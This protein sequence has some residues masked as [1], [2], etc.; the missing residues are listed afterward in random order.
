MTLRQHHYDVAFEAW[1]QDRRVPYVAVDETFRSRFAEESLKSFDFVVSLPPAWRLLVDVK[2]RLL[3]GREGIES[4]ATTDD[5]DSLAR[6]Q[7]VF[8][9]GFRATLLFAYSDRVGQGP[10]GV[11]RRNSAGVSA[12]ASAETS[13]D[14]WFWFRGRRYQFFGVWADDYRE[15]MR[16]RSPKWQT[17]WLRAADFRELRWPLSALWNGRWTAA[18]ATQSVA[19]GAVGNEPDGAAGRASGLGGPRSICR[20]EQRRDGGCTACVR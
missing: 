13:D 20:R 16:Q 2:G 6:W 10:V 17:V 7:Q 11:Q 4:W 18:P 19:N 12:T 3:R 8:G 5:L 9:S 1:L 14:D 15:R